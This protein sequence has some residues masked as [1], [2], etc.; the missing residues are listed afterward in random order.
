M[1]LRTN[2]NWPSHAPSS[3]TPA[4]HS[5]PPISEYVK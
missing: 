5:T 2:A 3:V 4:A 1:L